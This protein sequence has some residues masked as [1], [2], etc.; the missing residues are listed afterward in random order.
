M[1]KPKVQIIEN[2]DSSFKAIL[3]NVPVE[4]ANSIR[5]IIMSEVRTIAIDDVFIFRNDSVL[6]DD[7]LAHRLGL[8]PL[9]ASR[10]K[11][12][13]L[14]GSE[15][16][17][18]YIT[19]ILK[20][21]ARE[22]PVTVYSGD[23]KSRDRVV[24]PL[25]DKIELVKLAPGQA[26]EAELW[27][28]VGS[29]SEH[30]KWSPVSVAV[31]RGIPKIKIKKDPPAKVAKKIK[32]ICPKNVFTVDGGKLSVDDALKC[33]LCMLCEKEYPEYVKVSID[34]SSSLIYFEPIGQL[35]NREIIED[36]FNI[37]IDK[38]KGFMSAFKEVE[39]NVA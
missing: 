36:A 3:K 2:S 15:D 24:K 20:V 1:K 8:I 25:S 27:A 31:V 28:R 21:S 10:K 18:D 30:A 37:L 11:I 39:I 7:T 26:I 19:L 29:G 6:N 34:E 4:V 23:I 32:E 17:P 14:I 38:L 13:K 22:E 35:S 5:R 9:K 16:E 12:D 33:T